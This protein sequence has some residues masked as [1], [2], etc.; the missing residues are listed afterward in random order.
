MTF[1]EMRQDFIDRTAR[2]PDGKKGIKMYSHPKSSPLKR[3]RRTHT[4]REHFICMRTEK[5]SSPDFRLS[6][7]AELLLVRFMLYCMDK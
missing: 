7:L 3:E 5:A 2:K 4:P 1:A 6:C